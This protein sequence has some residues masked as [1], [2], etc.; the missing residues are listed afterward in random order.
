MTLNAA[1]NMGGFTRRHEHF[2]DSFELVELEF[3]LVWRVRLA[4]HE[5]AC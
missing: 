4:T 3:L 1:R 2:R 5:V